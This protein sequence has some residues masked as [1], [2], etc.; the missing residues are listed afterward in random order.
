MS[1]LNNYTFFPEMV[2]LSE[3]CLYEIESRCGMTDCMR[4]M[5]YQIN[6][7]DRKEA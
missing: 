3:I 4:L 5:G 7:K 6:G 2:S 1:Y